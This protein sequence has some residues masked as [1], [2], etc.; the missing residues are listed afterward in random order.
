MLA[1]GGKRL[2]CPLPVVI[3]LEVPWPSPHPPIQSKFSLLAPVPCTSF[4]PARAPFVLASSRSPSCS[5]S[6]SVPG[7][8][9]LSVPPRPKPAQTSP[10]HSKPAQASPNQPKPAETTTKKTEPGPP[11]LPTRVFLRAFLRAFL[12]QYSVGVPKIRGSGGGAES[13]EAD[14]RKNLRC[15]A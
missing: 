7:R 5:S 13:S 9:L 1:C 4:C 6:P 8:A 11:R 10:N 12:S 3:R 2:L 15:G 14:L